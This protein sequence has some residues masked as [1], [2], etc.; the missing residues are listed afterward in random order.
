MPESVSTV[1][2]VFS[3]TNKRYKDT[4]IRWQHPQANRFE[5]DWPIIV[6]THGWSSSYDERYFLGIARDNFRRYKVSFSQEFRKIQGRDQGQL[7]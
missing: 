2:P 7:L 6:A 3:L 1:N 4:N 5:K